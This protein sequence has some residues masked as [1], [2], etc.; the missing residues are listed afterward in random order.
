MH[1]GAKKDLNG[2]DEGR[3]GGGPSPISSGRLFEARII[4]T[5]FI[6]KDGDLKNNQHMYKR[7]HVIVYLTK[8]NSKYFL[9]FSC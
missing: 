2:Q 6:E 1:I 4:I 8:V 9:V 5:T 3:D 7:N